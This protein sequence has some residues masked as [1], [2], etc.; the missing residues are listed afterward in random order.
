M[1]MP[2][3][4]TW[5]IGVGV[6]VALSVVLRYLANEAHELARSR[7]HSAVAAEQ[8][9]QALRGMHRARADRSRTGRRESP[10]AG[11]DLKAMQPSLGEPDK[12]L[13]TG[14]L[15]DSDESRVPT[16]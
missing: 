8:K 3:L 4:L 11:I 16:E 15:T 12:R 2:S 14:S 5:V 1:I 9:T 7:G 13:G 10:L 6:L